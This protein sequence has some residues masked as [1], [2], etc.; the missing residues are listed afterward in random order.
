MNSAQG[1]GTNFHNDILNAW[2]P[3]NKNSDIPKLNAKASSNKL[4]LFPFLD[5]GIVFKLA[6][7]FQ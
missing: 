5:F 2:T 4:N 1:A 7:I 6:E 3:E